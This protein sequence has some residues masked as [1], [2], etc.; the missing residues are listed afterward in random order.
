MKKIKCVSIIISLT[1]ILSLFA[2]A[3]TVSPVFASTLPPSDYTYTTDADDH[4]TIT[5]YTG[6]ADTVTIP[7]TIDG[8]PVYAIGDD[9]FAS[10]AI[11]SVTIPSGVTSIGKRAFKYSSLAAISIPDSV[12]AVDSW[13][14]SYCKS[15][16]KIDLPDS[17]TSMG[18]HVFQDA[19]MLT[20]VNIPKNL[21]T[22]PEGTFIDCS[23]LKSIKIPDS[24]KSI[25][26][27]A[28]YYC[29]ALS[30]APLPE[31]LE[32]IGDQAFRYCDALP[33]VVIPDSVTS[34][35]SNAFQAQLYAGHL[36]G[37]I[38]EGAPP[39]TM[40]T[41]VFA[42]A[43]SK[44]KVYYPASLAGSSWSGYTS[45]WNT[46]PTE[47]YASIIYALSY[48][49]NGGTFSGMPLPVKVCPFGTLE[50]VKPGTICTKA[51]A[52][53]NNW[54]TAADGTGERYSPGQQVFIRNKNITLYAQWT[55]IYTINVTPAANG[56]VTANS[57]AA[58]LEDNITVSAIAASG[59]Q[60][61]AGSLKYNDGVTDTPIMYDNGSYRFE[62]PASD[63][64]ISA[65]F[66]SINGTSTGGG[67]GGS[68]SNNAKTTPS[69]GQ[70][71]GTVTGAASTEAKIA[72]DGK[73]AAAFT[74]GQISDVLKKADAD[75]AKL[76][77]DVKKQIE[78]NVTGAS[79]ASSIE[80]TLPK[81]SLIAVAKEKPETMKVSTPIA[82]LGFDRD[83][84]DTIAA[85]A[86]G[87]VK[88]SASKVD[89]STLSEDAKQLVGDR[90]VFN[91]SVTSGNDTISQFKGEVTVS[92]PYTLKAGEDP[93]SVVIYY[94][95]AAG[96]PEVVSNCVYDSSTGKITFTTS[97]F[98]TYAVG[99]N[100]VN[101]SDIADSAWYSNA[102]SYIAARGISNG[103]GSGAFNPNGH[104]TRGEFLVMTMRAYGIEPSANAAENFTDA[105]STY[106]TNYLA[107]AKTLGIT[108]GVG[109][110]MF[111]PEKSI[112][113]QE[114]VALL[115]NTLKSIGK[116]PNNDSSAKLSGFSDADSVADW[117]DEAMTL[118]VNANI[119]SGS[120]GTINPTGT[121]SRAEMAQTLYNL[122][123]R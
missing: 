8:D 63:I 15:L 64:T 68:S 87:D 78:I 120:N 11:K 27:A 41:D 81:E 23:A 72:A 13:A 112:T 100:K 31:D 36:S 116:L 76:G 106:Y 33:G 18:D 21:T 2:G 101:F 42:Q 121:T 58:E 49:E 82:T 16:T 84:L 109:N 118:F 102:V 66:E 28:F 74:E 105:G 34:I 67:G 40:G 39:V 122:L 38:F 57:V 89:T 44:F 35:G 108:D 55:N 1:L 50:E 65:V 96:K 77:A 114:M 4:V 20:E 110:N 75:A 46:Y 62:M 119:I 97:H 80:T 117:A 98:S 86:T 85:E 48:N 60:L 69:V 95:N 90:P 54:N 10:T 123:S 53:F 71:G 52:R 37:A 32:S 47:S 7:T 45:L 107:A 113:R 92:V 56:T 25:G 43:P 93:A 94:I 83:A 29:P 3:Q 104:L 6:S 5:K 79:G 115:Y 26:S 111:A 30:N 91:F 19:K 9:A 73:A 88:F 103:N 17:I 59:Y 51:G 12:T 24:I 99:Y 22:L 61:K 14:F 70:T